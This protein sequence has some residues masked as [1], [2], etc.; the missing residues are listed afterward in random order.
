MKEFPV[1]E[2]ELREGWKAFLEMSRCMIGDSREETV[3]EAAKASGYDKVPLRVKGLI[4]SLFGRAA[5][6]A[7]WYAVRDV[8]DSQTKQMPA[9]INYHT[10]EN[11]FQEAVNSL[12]GD[13]SRKGERLIKVRDEQ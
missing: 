10:L 6:A 8:T 3:A 13:E 2:E 7:F 12:D 1:S 9:W 4:D 5:M 11:M